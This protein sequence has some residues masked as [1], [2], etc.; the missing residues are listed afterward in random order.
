MS[1]EKEKQARLL[2]KIRNSSGRT[3]LNDWT[4]TEYLGRNCGGDVFKIIKNGI[5]FSEQ[6]S[7]LKII[8]I[9]HAENI[10]SFLTDIKL[11][12]KIQIAKI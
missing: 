2:E 8:K 4:V 7:A 11:L 6:E 12:D 3:F 5:P 10:E 9:N 1:E